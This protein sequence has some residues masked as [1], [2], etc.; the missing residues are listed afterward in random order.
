MKMLK[1]DL[2]GRDDIEHTDDLYSRGGKDLCESCAS[3]INGFKHRRLAHYN[4]VIDKEVADEIERVRVMLS[5][6]IDLG[7]PFK[8]AL[9]SVQMKLWSFKPDV[10]GAM[11]VCDHILMDRDEGEVKK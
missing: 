4:D 11:D 3:I 9:R 10:R 5:A 2:C 7:N 6:P 8:E 1:C